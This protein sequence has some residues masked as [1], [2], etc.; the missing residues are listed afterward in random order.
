MLHLYNSQFILPQERG[1]G[2][3]LRELQDFHQQ[4][5]Q[6]LTTRCLVSRC[7]WIKLMVVCT[8]LWKKE[9]KTKYVENTIKSLYRTIVK[10]VNKI[11]IKQ[12]QKHILFEASNSRLTA[13]GL[14]Q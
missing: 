13:A 8:W 12:K 1:V 3:M 11:K 5:P 7:Y 9:R 14:I 4:A 10:N 2:H 6:A